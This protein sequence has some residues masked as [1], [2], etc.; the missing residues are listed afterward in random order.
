MNLT[1]SQILRMDD[2]AATDS[3]QPLEKPGSSE[4]TLE[5]EWVVSACAGDEGAFRR[6]V[7]KYQDRAFETALRIVRSREDAQEAT[8]E[9]FLRVW[10]A[11]PGFRSESRFSTWL[12]R[13]VTRCALDAVRSRRRRQERE[14]GVEPEILA[15]HAAPERSGL[16]VTD[17]MRL[18]TVLG[19][20]DA[21][22]RA[23]VTLHYMLQQS[24]A[25]IAET[26]A[27]PEGTVKTSLHRS[28]AIL[29]KAWNRETGGGTL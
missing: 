15:S 9:A 27:M 20:L 18:H 2:P 5:A 26:L 11:L 19:K 10:R 8:Q 1:I 23:V 12:Y 25:E 13:I 14:I 4:H 7:E 29:R 17:L 28:R 22:K 21:R 6:L 16:P 3:D 24:I